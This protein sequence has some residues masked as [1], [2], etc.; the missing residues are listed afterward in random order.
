M[1]YR[2]SIK[3]CEQ[4][5]SQ[6]NEMRSQEKLEQQFDKFIGQNSDGGFIHVKKVPDKKDEPS[7]PR[8]YAVDA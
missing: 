6:L 8:M 3:K 7:S 5:F 4:P 2:D 1:F